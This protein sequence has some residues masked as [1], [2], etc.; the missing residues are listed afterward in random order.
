MKQTEVRAAVLLHAASAGLRGMPFDELAPHAVARLARVLRCD[1]AALY[2]VEPGGALRVRTRC[3]K[4]AVT[5]PAAGDP[6]LM[7]ALTGEETHPG[8]RTSGEHRD[9]AVAVR[10]GRRT[11]GVLAVRRAGPAPF[12]RSDHRFIRRLAE[13]LALAQRAER[14]AANARSLFERSRQVFDNNPNPM[15]LVDAE[16]L[17]YVDVNQAAV[18]AYGYAREQW[19]TMT[20]YDL[21]A[22]REKGGLDDMLRALATGDRNDAPAV[23]RKADGSR[24]E[25]QVSVVSIVREARRTHVV[26]VQDMTQRNEALARSRRS[27][28]TLARAQR[29]LAHNAVHDRLTGL[30]NRVLL[31]ERLTGTIERARSRGGMAAVLF[32]D[33]DRFKDVNDSLGHAAGD[34]LLREL[35]QR[36]RSNTRQADCVAR[37]GGDEFIGVLGDITQVAHVESI[38]RHLCSVVSQPVTIGDRTVSTSCSIGVALYPRD[39]EDA[40]TLIRNADMAM[41]EAKRGGRGIARFFAPAMHEAVDQRVRLEARLRA[42]VEE[43]AFTLAYQPIYGLE[44]TLAGSEA[45]IRWPQP[46]GT[47]VGPDAFIP[48][49]EESGLIVPIGAAVLHA[50]CAQNAAWNREA[51]L[52]LRVNVNVSARQIA[53]P[54]FAGTVQSALRSS[55]LRPELLELELTE[56]AMS[57][58]VPRNAATV[59]RL[60]AMGVRIAIDDFGTG[61]NSLAT[62]RAYRIDTLKLDMCFVTEIAQ[63]EVDRAIASAVIAAAHGLGASVVAEGIETVEQRDALLRLRCDSGQGFLFAAA[64]P[65]ENFAQLLARPNRT[66]RA[67]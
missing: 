19:L 34:A 57:E 54:D 39:G 26:T 56:T 25:A 28:A 23:H 30:P 47:L 33:I 1:V 67:A 64:M 24:L 6:F 58:N 11:F 18:D 10:G 48:F 27:E 13:L 62:L 4:A 5:P 55:G 49:A 32:V 8:E 40:D 37:M 3:G 46:D 51:P 17:R 65:P 50:A 20:P 60:R 21:R 29:E 41:Y 43:N 44:G 42:A 35:A 31:Q 66:F 63:S 36:L 15:M 9:L 61:Y 14:R 59:D 12:T 7:E 38:V 45:L 53:D 2:E 52:P 16:T 22:P